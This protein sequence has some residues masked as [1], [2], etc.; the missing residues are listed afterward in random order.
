MPDQ[1]AFHFYGLP[2]R[3]QAVAFGPAGLVAGGWRSDP[4]KGSAVVWTSPDG[5]HWSSAWQTSF[6]G[7]Q[8]DAVAIAAGARS[9]SGGRATRT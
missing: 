3:M 4:G 8:I 7:A 5:Q 1:D 9:P 6:S 2:V